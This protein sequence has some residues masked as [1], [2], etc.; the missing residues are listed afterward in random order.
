MIDPTKK[1]PHGN[2]ESRQLN[3]SDPVAVIN[4]LRARSNGLITAVGDNSVAVSDIA[5]CIALLMLVTAHGIEQSLQRVRP[6]V[7]ASRIPD[8]KI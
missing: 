2:G 8:L 3:F 5:T 1:D 6:V 4:E 7:G